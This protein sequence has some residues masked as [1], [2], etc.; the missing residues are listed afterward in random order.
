M[1]LHCYFTIQITVFV[2]EFGARGR[3]QH[4]E[5]TASRW[6]GE[7][8]YCAVMG[9]KAPIRPPRVRTTGGKEVE[10]P[11]YGVHAKY[12]SALRKSDRSLLS[13]DPGDPLD[14]GG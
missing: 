7:H 14:F 5:R 11:K 6:G 3:R 4:A 8:G 9:Q 1:A 10:T 2:T 13:S 12:P